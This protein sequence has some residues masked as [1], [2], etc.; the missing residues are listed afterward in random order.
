MRRAAG[1]DLRIYGGFLDL[2]ERPSRLAANGRSKTNRAA[3]ISYV[4]I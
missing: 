3:I 1:S 2:R 4:E